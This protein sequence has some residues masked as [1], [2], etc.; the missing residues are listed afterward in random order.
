VKGEVTVDCHR[1]STIKNA[2]RDEGRVIEA[3]TYHDLRACRD[4][5]LQ[6]MLEMSNC[7]QLFNLFQR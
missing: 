5:Q 3:G 2:D 4:G 1:L 6:E 7:I